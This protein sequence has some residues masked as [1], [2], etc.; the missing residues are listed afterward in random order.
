MK[1]EEAHLVCTLPGLADTVWLVN[2]HTLH[3]AIYR[4]RP[5]VQRLVEFILPDVMDLKHQEQSDELMKTNWIDSQRDSEGNLV[6]H[7]GHI[8][9]YTGSLAF[10]N[11]MALDEDTIED[12]TTMEFLE[13]IAVMPKRRE[14]GQKVDYRDHGNLL[15][16]YHKVKDTFDSTNG[17]RKWSH[18]YELL[19]AETSILTYETESRP[20]EAVYGSP[21]EFLVLCPLSKIQLQHWT[22]NANGT[23]FDMKERQELP[24]LVDGYWSSLC[25]SY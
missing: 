12:P 14:K 15:S 11:M 24:K 1:V 23:K 16:V 25:I 4:V 22:L 7:W 10:E 2:P 18:T 9:A 17:Q 13:K 5:T 6:L 19:F 21:Q 3:S 20:I 8:N